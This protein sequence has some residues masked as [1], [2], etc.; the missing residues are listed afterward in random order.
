MKTHDNEKKKTRWLADL[1]DAAKLLYYA[2][3]LEW[4]RALDWAKENLTDLFD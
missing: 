1:A 3:S 2:R 4:K